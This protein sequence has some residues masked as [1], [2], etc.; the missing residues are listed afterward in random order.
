MSENFPSYDG[1]PGSSLFH[2][3]IVDGE[4]EF[5]K[6]LCFDFKMERLFSFLV[7]YGAR[8]TGI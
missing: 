4:K 1:Q 3:E 7:V 5:L 6:K 8:L 2:S